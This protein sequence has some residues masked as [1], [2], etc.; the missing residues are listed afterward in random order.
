MYKPA[1]VDKLREDRMVWLHSTFKIKL[2][3]PIII[4]QDV[5]AIART[6]SLHEHYTTFTLK[7]VYCVELCSVCH[8]ARVL[9]FYTEKVTWNI[10]ETCLPGAKT[11]H[12]PKT[13]P[14]IAR[15]FGNNNHPQCMIN[16]TLSG[17]QSTEFAILSGFSIE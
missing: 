10:D 16:T 8:Y 9:R 7:L 14:L 11:Q 15:R 5:P 3:T 2:Y 6:V 4:K 13:K 12:M 17:K 1:K